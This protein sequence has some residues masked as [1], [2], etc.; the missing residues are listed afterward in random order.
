M[1]DMRDI[2]RRTL[3]IY[4]YRAKKTTIRKTEIEMA[5]RLRSLTEYFR[6]EGVVGEYSE[7]Q[8]GGNKIARQLEAVKTKIKTQPI[9]NR[10]AS[11]EQIRRAMCGE[12]IQVPRGDTR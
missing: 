10:N 2:A 6:Q 3:A 5:R 11:R 1:G 8:T 12:R 9:D 7:I 4:T